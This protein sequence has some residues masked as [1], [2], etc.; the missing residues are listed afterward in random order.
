MPDFFIYFVVIL[1]GLV[2]G[3]FISAYTYRLPKGLSIVKGRSFCPKC[4]NKI[5]WFDNIPI[6]SF[7][8]LRGKCRNCGKPISLRYSMIEF[9][10]MSVFL[11]I[12]IRYLHC[13]KLDITITDFVCSWNNIIGSFN[14]FYQLFIA[15]ILV[16]IFVIDLEKKIIPDRLSLGLFAIVLLMFIFFNPDYTYKNIFT[17]FTAASFLLLVNFVTKGK[18]MGF[19]D[20]KL[21][22]PL[23]LML[24]WPLTISWFLLSFVIGALVGVALILAK[25]TTLGKEIPFG[26]FLVIGY[27]LTIIWGDLIILRFF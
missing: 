20:V 3:S 13:S 21:A 16:S 22:L 24:G 18:G 15:A 23:G 1:F 19:G 11:L 26:P 8:L 25:K 12:T 9:F 2:I 7:Y 27:F 10:T 17:G 5:S 4:H 6:L 14:L